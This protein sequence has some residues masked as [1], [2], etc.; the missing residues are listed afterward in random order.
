MSV[1]G[2]RQSRTC[3]LCRFEAANSDEFRAHVADAHGWGKPTQGAGSSDRGAIFVGIVSI[4]AF[5]W[6]AL[7]SMGMGFIAYRYAPEVLTRIY[8][9]ELLGV[10][11]VIGFDLVVVLGKRRHWKFRTPAA[12]LSLLIAV[13]CFWVSSTIKY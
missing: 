13:V 8:V 6:L 5:L 10:T 2:T 3:A 1:V 4:A 11:A 9:L 12:A 7:M